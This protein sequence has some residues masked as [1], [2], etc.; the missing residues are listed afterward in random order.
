MV[1]SISS[2]ISDFTYGLRLRDVPGDVVDKAKLHVLDTLGIMMAT[3]DLDDVKKVVNVARILGGTP[4]STVIGHSFKASAPN[5][6]LA[7]ASMAHS[8]DYDDTHLGSVVHQSCTAIPTALAVGEM[9]NASGREFLEAVIA[10]YEVNA[11]LGLSAP[12]LFHLRG[13]HPTSAIGVF[14]SALASGK[15]M[16]LSVEKLEWALGIAGSLSSGILQGSSEG[17]WVKPMHPGFASHSGIIAS[18]LAREGCRGPLQVFEGGKGLFNAYLKG[19][20]FNLEEATKGLGERWETLK[21]SIKP[22]PTCHATHAPIDVALAFRRKYNIKPEEI[23]ECTYY[24]PRIA[25]NIVVEPYDEKIK[26]KTPYAAKFSLPYVVVV[27]LRRGFVGLWDFTEESVRD[28]ETLKYT[29][30]IKALVDEEY[31]KYRGGE[32]S[33]AR[34][35][36]RLRSGETYVEEA[37]NHK[38]TPKNPLTRD[39]V[40]AKFMDNIKKSKYR[41][42]GREVVDKVLNIEKYSIKEIMEILQ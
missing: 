19:D 6:A 13:I 37:V 11:R 14:G 40:V 25:F 42:V 1:E 22:Y 2:R 27:A 4:E 41:D 23:E 24:V 7:N 33:P 38:G 30:K 39:D 35:R 18:L 31:D 15:L 12:W 20:R 3:H 36:I 26:P 8:V 32:V 10:S 21:I 29:P 5:A 34:A 16:G 28:P 17:V 9:V